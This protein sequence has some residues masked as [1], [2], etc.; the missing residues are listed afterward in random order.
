MAAG[1]ASLDAENSLHTDKWIRTLYAG[2]RKK[3][4]RGC[5]VAVYVIV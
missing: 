2:G 1:L 3:S 4:I 5:R